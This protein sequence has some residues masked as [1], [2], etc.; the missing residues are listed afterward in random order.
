MVAE[1]R[2]LTLLDPL[3]TMRSKY[4]RF[5]GLAPRMQSSSC[6]G[7]SSHI[8]NGRMLS[9]HRSLAMPTLVKFVACS[10]SSLDNLT[11]LSVPTKTIRRP[12][13]TKICMDNC[14]TL[15]DLGPLP[16][17]LFQCVAGR[18]ARLRGRESRCGNNTGRLG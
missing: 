11:L 9:L 17:E 1:Y 5:V 3:A 16:L 13:V 6:R 10:F 18:V 2:S 12:R 14:A 7:V 4:S 8:S 15:G